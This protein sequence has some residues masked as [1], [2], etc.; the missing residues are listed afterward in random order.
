MH[1]RGWSFERIADL[2]H[3]DPWFLAQIEDLV[4][5][6]GLVRSEGLG[7]LDAERGVDALVDRHDIELVTFWRMASRACRPSFERASEKPFA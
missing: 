5:E 1:S 3:I 2:T 4:K 7:A 6:E